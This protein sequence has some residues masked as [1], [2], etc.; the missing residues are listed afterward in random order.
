MAAQPDLWGEI[1]VPDGVPTPTTIL[2]QQASLLG[3]KTQNLIEARVDTVTAGTALHHSFNLVVPTLDNYTYTLFTVWHRVGAKLYPVRVS[4][5]TAV[6]SPEEF[7]EWL[8]KQ[9]S[10]QET[11]KILNNLLAQ[12]KS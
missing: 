12:V 7:T 11:K 5:N 3:S 6:D 10:S 9:L 8:G 1:Q 2:R 4:D